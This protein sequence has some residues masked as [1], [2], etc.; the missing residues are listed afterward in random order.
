MNARAHRRRAS[1][2]ICAATLALALALD[3]VPS[4]QAANIAPNPSFE[5]ICGAGIPC[6]WFG[7]GGSFPSSDT[8]NPHSGL[9]SFRI[10]ATQAEPS[11]T[12]VSDCFAVT[13]GTTYNLL[14]FYRTSSARVTQI[15][16]GP[17]YWSN[18]DCTGSNFGAGGA[19]TNSA[20]ADG[21]WHSV[22]GT[23]TAPTNP[24]FNAQSAQLQIHFGCASGCQVNDAANYD[25]A[26]MDTNP[27]AATVT[28]F[29]AR[30]SGT[31][32]VL[33]WRTGSEVDTLGFDV[34]RQRGTGS[35]VRV[36]R[37]LLPALGAVAGSSYS[38]TDRR[39]PRHRAVRYWLQDVDTHGVRTWHG[40]VQ[41]GAG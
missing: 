4:A 17:L 35:R 20:V 1:I 13:A 30:R 16:Y 21:N 23:T 37:R 29:S 2:F 25:D 5:D 36:N 18:A 31:R 9:R 26:V 10:T 11:T 15:L 8:N 33:R 6:H 24:P 22:S 34:F 28:G 3:V 12:A 39:A 7:S 40:P 19:S 27:L 14:L 41:V 38:F 32:I